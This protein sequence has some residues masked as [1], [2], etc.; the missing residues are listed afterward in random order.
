[1]KY[2]NIFFCTAHPTKNMG[3]VKEYFIKN[4]QNFVAFHFF[5]GY[6][7]DPSYVE[8][9]SQ[10]KKVFEKKFSFYKGKNKLIQ[11]ILNYLYFSYTLLAYVNRGSFLLINAPIYC[12]LNSIFS[13]LKG[14]TYILWIGDYYPDK[15]FPMNLYHK[16]VEFYNKRMHY[17][18]YVSPPVAK[19]Y[20]KHGID[21]KKFRKT[22]S[23]GIKKEYH[24]RRNVKKKNIT[25]GFIGI[26][27]LQQ[28]LDLCFSYLQ[29]TDNCRF[30][31]VG[32]GYYLQYY[33][34]MA[35]DLGIQ[36]KVKF[37][38]RVDDISSIVKK[39]DIGVALYEKKDSNLSIYCEP[40]KIKNYLSFG[41]PVITTGTTYFSKE[42][43]EYKAGCVIEENV[44]S[45]DKAI[46]EIKENNG[47]YIKGVDFLVDKYEYT[48][49]Y[50]EQ[51]KF[52]Q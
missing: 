45:L 16:F 11:N 27:R 44:D 46:R 4:S 19:I 41:I 21:N 35:K 29:K 23:L 28:G 22:I 9:Y 43:K 50:G 3:N 52:L 49:W 39:W 26:I 42:I 40:T 6:A 14:F 34:Q 31:V 30:E 25:L 24:Q 32:D 12:F 48:S 1:M 7:T 13:F 36:E 33:K 20:E 38:G 51:F 2:N 8:K 47:S 10:G 5:L 18:L 37:Y 17:V 15:K